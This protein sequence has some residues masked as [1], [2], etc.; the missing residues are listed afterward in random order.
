MTNVEIEIDAEERGVAAP[1][2]GFTLAHVSDLHL[3][4]LEG[5]RARALFDKRILGYVS[6][7]LRRRHEHRAD[8]LDALRSDL[9]AA[10]LDHIAVTGDLTH[11]GLPQEFREAATWL[12]RL[13][14]PE[15]VTVVP[16]NHDAYVREPWQD[17]FAQWSAY[18]RGDGAGEG[19]ESDAVFPSLRVRGPLAL[20]GLST[21]RPSAPFLAT[22]RL[23]ERQLR[24]L[25]RVLEQTGASGLF[26]VVLLHHPP[27]RHTVRWRK[28]LLDGAALREVLAGRGAELVL[29]GHAHFSAATYLDS[30]RGRNLAIGVPSAS[31]IGGGVDRHATYHVYRIVRREAGWRLRVSVR[32]FSAD[33]GRFVP[34]DG[35]RLRLALA[36]TAG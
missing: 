7:R 36:A 6:W 27:A 8:V 30:A 24:R 21:A 17:T 29:H 35:R 18:M 14:G 23:G 11:L 31:A 13:G 32:A 12:E 10:H 25:D 15:G 28:S 1:D 33:R 9:Q 19:E 22:G 16:G 26:R 34:E 4:T 20:I 5:V 3:S 2:A